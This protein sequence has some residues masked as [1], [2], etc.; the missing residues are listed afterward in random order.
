[1]PRVTCYLPRDL[2]RRYVEELPR[3]ESLSRILQEALEQR[4]GPRKAAA[5]GADVA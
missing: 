4:L 5:R 1:M 3:S 2:H